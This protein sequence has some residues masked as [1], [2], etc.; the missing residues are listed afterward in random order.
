MGWQGGSDDESRLVGTVI[1]EQQAKLLLFVKHQQQQ[2]QCN[3]NNKRQRGAWPTTRLRLATGARG[4]W[5]TQATSHRGCTCCCCRGLGLG[6]CGGLLVEGF[7]R[8]FMHM[9]ACFTV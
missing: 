5:V 1:V 2:Q 3:N 6:G 8:G 4:W 9:Q 7:A